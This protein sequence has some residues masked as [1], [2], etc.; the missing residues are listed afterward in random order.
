MRK[1]SP[2]VLHGGEPVAWGRG[3]VARGTFVFLSGSEGRDLETDV[4]ASTIGEQTE[5]T[6][7]KIK[8][9]LEEYGT[10]CENIVQQMTF[11]TD[12]DEWV[13]QGMWYQ[14]RWLRKNAPR[15]LQD[16]PAGT[17]IG[18]NRLNLPEMKV[19]IQVIAVIPDGESS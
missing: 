5:V 6:W 13:R 18:V 2:P 15:L 16:K 11:V 9:R 19:E 3:C 14:T 10:S 12:M 7:N 1:G 4:C 17:L 8:V